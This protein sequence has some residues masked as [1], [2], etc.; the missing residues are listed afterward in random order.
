M[1]KYDASKWF[2]YSVDP[3]DM[4]GLG[5]FKHVLNDFKPDKVLLFQDIF[6][7]DM[8]IPMIRQ[9]NKN[10]PILSYFPIDGTPVNRSWLAAM[11][12]SDKLVTYTKWGIEVIKEALPEL[13]DTPIDYLYHGVDF[14]AFN[15][16]PG[17]LQRRFKE[18]HG[19]KDKFVV[20]SNN[21][22]QPRKVLPLVLRSFILF[23]KGY[24]VC[25]CGNVYL[26]T[27]EKCDLNR[28]DSSTVVKTVSGRNDSLIYLHCNTQE[29]M[30]GPGPGNSLQAHLI[31]AGFEDA[32]VN[33]IVNF[34]AGL[35]IYENPLSE[36]DLNIL[37][38]CA[39]VNISSSL[40][41]GSLIKG[42]MVFTQ[43]EG[44]IPIEQVTEASYVLNDKTKFTVVNKTM[45]KSFPKRAIQITP[46]K[47][48]PIVLSE[49]HKLL[50]TRG[51]IRA[52]QLTMNDRLIAKRYMPLNKLPKR[53]DLS[54]Y[55]NNLIEVTS[56]YIKARSGYKAAR[57]IDITEDFCK[58]LGLYVAEGSSSDKSDVTFS[59]HK[60]ESDLYEFISNWYQKNINIFNDYMKPTAKDSNKDNSISLRLSGNY[61][62][63][64]LTSLVG[65]GAHNKTFPMW[66]L[67]LPKKYRLA[68]VE[69]LVDGDGYRSKN[70]KVFRLRTVS[71]K[72]AYMFRELLLTLDTYAGISLQDN[73]AGYGNG[74]IYSIDFV[75]VGT[76]NGSKEKGHFVKKYI[77]KKDQV[78]LELRSIE[79][80]ITEELSYDLEVPE[81][82]S[83]RIGQCTSHNCG[84]S[85]VEAAATG[86]TN[87]A[88]NN[89]AIP[90]MLGD[91]NHIVPNSAH[92]NM[93]MDSGHM[94][95]LVSI[96]GMI[97]A[98]EI[99]YQKWL[100]NGK[101]KVINQAA[102][103]RAKQIF[104][105][106]DKQQQMK[107]WLWNLHRA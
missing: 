43:Q 7:I 23:N 39:D 2:I 104:Q 69:G 19:W 102:I 46:Y 90:E 103:D 27:R 16:I 9:F 77:L 25:K 66:V 44:Y 72:L 49:D 31:N 48:E 79:S 93:G 84:L 59:F 100:A 95:P 22:F 64:L 40:G 11:K 94:R 105:W 50:T 81:G 60:D 98:L 78:E 91:I 70:R 75:S 5:R 85:L 83:Y 65:Q 53:I 63:N 96:Q 54:K 71:R 34:H 14:D 62:S 8:V 24:K 38:N 29:R 20:F 88:P 86:T 13:K 80:I 42:T 56:K 32:D 33:K 92:M 4:L 45:E 47:N 26:H 41:E 35:D 21:R 1:H 61:L 28:C 107:D 89:S 74:N 12:E 6:N 36:S 37:Y 67:D 76:E 87:I 17:T 55:D 101:R 106:E 51:Y 68:F 97:D 73:S 99:E 30:M 3:Q 82:E 15:L 18:Q 57:Y 58:F 52:D 10:I